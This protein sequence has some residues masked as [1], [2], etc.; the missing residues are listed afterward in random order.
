MF[1]E[2]F[3][4]ALVKPAMLLSRGLTFY[5]VLIAGGI[6]TFV[7]HIRVMRSDK[8]LNIPIDHR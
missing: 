2:I 8:A 3:G 4:E 7:A 6:V 1:G 5:A